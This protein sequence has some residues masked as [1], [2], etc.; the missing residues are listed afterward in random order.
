MKK[1]S[2]PAGEAETPV[3]LSVCLIVKDEERVLGRIL[4]AAVQFADELI[5]LDTGSSD[6]SREIAGEY[7]D[8]VFEEPW[9]NSFAGARNFAAS[10]AGCDFVMWLDA[11]DVMRPEEIEKLL[12]LKKR[13]TPQTDAVFMTYRNDGF[14]CDLGLRD[15]IHRRALAC[16]WEGD[17]HE[18]IPLGDGMNLMFCPEITIIHKKEQVN[19]PNRNMRIF[20]GVRRAGRLSGAYMLSYYV[21]ELAVRDETER[22]LAAWEQLLQTGPSAHRVQY[23]LVFLT[24]MLLRQK[25]YEKCRQLIDTAVEQYGVPLSA[26]LCY[27]LGLAAEGLGDFKEADRQYRLATEIPVDI[28]G[29][30]IAF[31][32]YDDYLPC[33]KLCALAYD[34]GETDESEA[35]NSRAGRAWPEGRAWRINRERFFT[36]PLPSG[37]EP[38]VSVIMPAYNVEAYVSE[39][40]SSVLDQSW[41]NFELIIVDNAS[42]DA[43]CDEIRRFSDPRIRFLQNDRNIGVAGSTN[44]AIGVSRGEY[45]A[46]MDADDVSLPD[47]LQAQLTAMENDPGIMVLG[48]ASSVIDPEGKAVGCTAA[49]P[50]SPKYFQARLLL[51]NLEFC[52][53]TAMI[54]KSFLDRH[55]L[56]YREGVPGL[57]DY[58]FYMEASKL[59]AISCLADIHHRYRVHGGGITATTRREMPAERARMYNRIRCDSLR[60]SGVRLNAQQESLLG[61]LLP[62]NVL[63]VWNRHERDTLTALFAEI[64]QQLAA[65]AFPAMRELDDILWQILNH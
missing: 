65:A 59:G 50:D 27:H 42:T 38:L 16:R 37:R 2:I 29:G 18:A 8:L 5:V 10:K 19:E 54:R 20:D 32:G 55:H 26:F 25:A 22:A 61:R 34:R 3:S 14:L 30:M 52:N 12:A 24:G 63:P 15:R 33:L 1:Q 62:E 47:R 39:A 46:L 64:R 9:Q 36:P 4:S 43:T 21:R 53:S 44:R 57:S 17:I 6:K 40:I 11:D 31:T 51:G 58:R 23:A 35:W 45:L 56:S 7:T 41:Q 60:M 48:T 49:L 28:S 13:L